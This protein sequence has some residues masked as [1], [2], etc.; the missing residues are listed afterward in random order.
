MLTVEQE[1]ATAEAGDCASEAVDQVAT[2]VDGNGTE[3]GHRAWCSPAEC[4]YSEGTPVHQ[5][6]LSRWEDQ[7]ADLEVESRLL[8]PADDPNVYVELSLRDLRLRWVQY[9]GFLRVEVA[10]RLRDQLSAHL[11]AVERDDAW[12]YFI[13][14]CGHPAPIGPDCR[15][16]ECRVCDA[17]R[18]TVIDMRLPAT[19][20]YTINAM[21]SVDTVSWWCLLCD[22]EATVTSAL[23]AD[24]AAV[25]HLVACHRAVVAPT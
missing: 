25:E 16:G 3:A 13:G 7:A 10:R 4:Y 17:Q 2:A 14:E 9:Y 15:V 20:L 22:H 8:G 21:V 1:A 24:T 19:E 6:A 12:A 23:V 5:Q 11:D 18:P